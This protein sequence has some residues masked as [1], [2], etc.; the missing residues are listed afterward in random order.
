MSNKTKSSAAKKAR[1]AAY[2]AKGSAAKNA[3]RKLE[4]HLKK[5]PNDLQG[6]A[7]LK[8]GVNSI[9]KPSGTRLGWVQEDVK[10]FLGHTPPS[11]ALARQVAQVLAHCKKVARMQRTKAEQAQRR[12]SSAKKAKDSS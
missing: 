8:A 2:A 12:T 10:A 11:R 3:K 6:A 7:A 1:Y 9:R 4:R 5:Y